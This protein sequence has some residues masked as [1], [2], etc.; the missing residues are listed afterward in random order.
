MNGIWRHEQGTV[1]SHVEKSVISL[2]LFN[3]ITWDCAEKMPCDTEHFITDVALC[4]NTTLCSWRQ[5]PFH[6]HIKQIETSWKWGKIRKSCKRSS[7]TILRVL[8]N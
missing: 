3:E 7:V 6:L 5:S 2:K 1:F 4:K 8:W